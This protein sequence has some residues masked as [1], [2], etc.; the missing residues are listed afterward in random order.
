[1][2]KIKS[3]HFYSIALLA[4]SPID[5]IDLSGGTIG[6]T[7]IPFHVFA[8]MY[9]IFNFHKLKKV[10]LSVHD[11]L[12]NHVPLICFCI[13]VCLSSIFLESDPLNLSSRRTLILIS[14]I[15]FSIFFVYVNQKYFVFILLKATKAYII[16]N[17]IIF[18][19]QSLMLVNLIPVDMIGSYV[20]DLMPI[21]DE[22]GIL[23]LHG[24][25][26]DSSRSAINNIFFLTVSYIASRQSL[27]QENCEPLPSWIYILGTL[28][29]FFTLSRNALAMLPIFILIVFLYDEKNTKILITAATF[30]ITWAATVYILSKAEL[31]TMIQ[32]MFV[33]SAGREYSTQVHFELIQDAVNIFL[34][35]TKT[36][37]IGRGWGTEYVYTS[38]YFPSDK[39]MYGNFHSGF[40]SAG[41][42]SGAIAGISYFRYM[43][44]PLLCKYEWR[45]FVIVLV[46]SNVFYQYFIQPSYWILLVGLNTPLLQMKDKKYLYGEVAH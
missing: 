7:L 38:Q 24:L 2:N 22:E 42:Q 3:S 20:P 28:Q 44:K 12:R 13:A 9:T 1:M 34:S 31:V 36:F 45:Y 39:E 33:S 27:P 35:N 19:F 32:L 37:I 16:C 15:I 8:L 23:R 26:R 43:L 46:L 21:P 17:T 6:F 30:I 4:T 14:I 40:I 41:V 10:K 29:I 25:V 11:F 18:I 5:V